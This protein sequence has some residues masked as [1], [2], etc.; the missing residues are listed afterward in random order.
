MAPTGIEPATRGLGIAARQ[1]HVDAAS[2]AVTGDYATSLDAQTIAV[3]Y[4]YSRDHR[5]DLKQWMLSLAFALPSWRW[6]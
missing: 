2:L 4:G 6:P 1:V 5:E 3:T